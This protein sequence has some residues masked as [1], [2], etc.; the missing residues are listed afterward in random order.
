MILRFV[1]PLGDNRSKSIGA[2]PIEASDSDVS[3]DVRE[4]ND[5]VSTLSSLGTLR[6]QTRINEATIFLLS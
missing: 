2:E 3:G 1:R 4:Y 6:Q 5:F